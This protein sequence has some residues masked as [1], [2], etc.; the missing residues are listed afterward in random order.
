MWYA[1]VAY[2]VKL[3]IYKFNWIKYRLINF[4]LIQI[5]VERPCSLL[6]SPKCQKL[7]CFEI[8][9]NGYGKYLNKLG[10]YYIMYLLL[11]G[12]DSEK[13]VAHIIYIIMT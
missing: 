4:D 8:I 2:P 6:A 12:S 13:F 1:I 11:R 5:L 3:L 10:H 9:C 7:N